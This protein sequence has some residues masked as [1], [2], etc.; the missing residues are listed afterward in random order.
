MSDTPLDE[1][2][3]VFLDARQSAASKPDW[4]AWI[5]AKLKP[6][7]AYMLQQEA[8]HARALDLARAAALFLPWRFLELNLNS[9]AIREHLQRFGPGVLSPELVLACCDEIEVYSIAAEGVA[10]RA[11]VESFWTGRAE[12]LKAWFKAFV[13]VGLIQPSSA[14]AERGFSEFHQL[15]GSGEV[16]GALEDYMEASLMVKMNS[17]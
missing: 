6:A 1:R 8:K 17:H 12:D 10:R 7:H 9:G 14:A 15:F 11:S 5:R 13:I 4:L 3:S 2:I 16:P